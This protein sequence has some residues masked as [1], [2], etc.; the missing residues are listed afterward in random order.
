[1]YPQPVPLLFEASSIKSPAEE[2][3]S[4][5]FASKDDEDILNRIFTEGEESKIRV[6]QTWFRKKVSVK[7]SSGKVENDS[8]V[9]PTFIQ[10]SSQGSPY[11]MKT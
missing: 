3:V 1:M 9:T 7:K 11:L 6:I 4:P 2:D 5:P 8:T 10:P